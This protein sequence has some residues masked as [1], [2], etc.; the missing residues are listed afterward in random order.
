MT[1]AAQV[2]DEGNGTGVVFGDFDRDGFQDLF[3]AKGGFNPPGEQNRLFRNNGNGSFADISLQAGLDVVSG[4]F[5][6]AAG[7]FDQDG[8]LDLFVPAAVGQ[9]N[10]LYRND[11]RGAFEDVTRL[12]G[13]FSSR[14][15]SGAGAVFADYDNDGDVDLYAGVFGGTDIFYLETGEPEYTAISLG[16]G[17]DTV[18]MAIGDY[19]G[20]ADLDIYA[21]NLS[22]RSVLY[23]NDLASLEDVGS[24]SGTENF[25]VGTGAA[26]G[27]IDS[28]GDLDL[29]VANAHVANRVYV[30][31]DGHTFRDEAPA[32]DMADTVRSRAV[33]LADY[34]N[35]GDQDVYVVNEGMLNR[36]Y[37]NG[38][39]QHGWVKLGLRGT[40]SNPD[41]IGARVSVHSG[42][43]VLVR[44][45]NGTSGLAQG[46]RVQHVGLGSGGL[47]SVSVLW[48][49]GRIESF[50]DVEENRTTRLVE[51]EPITA[52]AEPV[53]PN[54]AF[55]LAP[56][57]PNPFNLTTVIPFSGGAG[58][59]RLI[60]YNSLG[61][62]VRA[63]FETTVAQAR[64][65]R[66]VWDGLTDAGA[67]AASGVYFARLTFHPS[68]GGGVR[69]KTRSLLLLR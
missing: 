21:V 60:V 46:S 29:F 61:Q 55:A 24:E 30:N 31:L 40:E 57:Y 2:A 20:D 39:S 66:V 14:A 54:P 52:V 5:G 49:S 68:D 28:D 16:N 9:V 62:R 42:G 47:D 59:M 13:I 50:R 67:P 17:G 4:S 64:V 63:L 56:N 27:D 43:R 45:V 65:F 38:G 6:A 18:G 69:H 35:D 44:E 25:G 51:G 33:L 37:E 8:Y 1:E 15:W 34:D 23:R 32:L 53:V 26:F 22:P 7:D 41:G 58:R 19:D 12:R 10:R 3:I 36:L 48:P 11:R